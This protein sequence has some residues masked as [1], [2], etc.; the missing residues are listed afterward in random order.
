MA[1]LNDKYPLSFQIP[2]FLLDPN[3]M[4]YSYQNSDDAQSK[5]YPVQHLQPTHRP[6]EFDSP[7]SQEDAAPSTSHTPPALPPPFQQDLLYPPSAPIIP[8]SLPLYSASGFDMISILAK[9]VNRPNPRIMLGPV[10]MTCSFLVADIRNGGDA[11]IVYASPTFCRLTGYSEPEILGRNC[12]FLQ[13][14]SGSLQRGDPR[15][16]TAPDAVRHIHRS[17]IQDKECQASL[18]NYRKDGSAFVNLVTLIPVC[19]D[20][21]DDTLITHYV[22]FQVDLAEQPGAI[23]QRLRDGSY[24][25]NYSMIG[26][27][28]VGVGAGLGGMGSRRGRGVSAELIEML[29]SAQIGGSSIASTSGVAAATTGTPRENDRADVQAFVLE[30]S[31]DFIHVLSLKGSLLYVSPAITRVLGYT[32]SELVGRSISD[33]CHPADIVPVMRE[34]KEASSASAGAGS[35]PAQHPPQQRGQSMGKATTNAPFSFGMHG[36]NHGAH[37]PSSMGGMGMGMNMGMGMGMNMGIG[38]LGMNMGMGVTPYQQYQTIYPAEPS[39]SSSSN[40]YTQSFPPPSSHPSIPHHTGHS[41][42][43]QNQFYG[44]PSIATPFPSSSSSSNLSSSTPSNLSTF[45]TP[46]RPTTSLLFRAL[47]KNGKYVWLMCRGRLHVEPGKGRKAVVMV[48]RRVRDVVVDDEGGGRGI[49][50]GGLDNER[51][52]GDADEGESE[53][54]IVAPNGL[55]L[56]GSSILLHPPP[57]SPPSTASSSSTAPRK[58]IPPPPSPLST[59]SGLSP[60]G[61]TLT[62]LVRSSDARKVAEAIASAACAN[63]RR[64]VKRVRCGLVGLG[65]SSE[66]GTSSGMSEDGEGEGR[67]V[68]I[69]FYAMGRE[70]DNAE[71][72]DEGQRQGGQVLPAGIVF[73][74][75]WVKEST[76]T[77][78]GGFS[79]AQQQHPGY[80]TSASS[81]PTESSF[82]LNIH[83]V[84]IQPHPHSRSVSSRASPSGSSPAS[85]H[86]S[87]RIAAQSQSQSQSPHPLSLSPSSETSW[88]YELTKLRFENER[89]RAEAMRLER[90]ERRRGVSAGSSSNSVAGGGEGM[91]VQTGMKR[92]RE[93]MNG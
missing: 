25:V 76:S 64:G 62:S 42:R 53:W 63:G 14:P 2:S 65:S 21:D 17:L 5:Y 13:S 90:R 58:Q 52:E 12:R 10:D 54:G 8:S 93:E 45:A 68:E 36:M 37:N 71:S 40:P 41:H 88:Q 79:V 38:G 27:G 66:A 18:I 28:G 6:F 82:P 46:S 85:T 22:G 59:S 44:P 57:P 60:I 32:A 61:K 20:D 84:P 50:G 29:R 87:T 73:E 69:R 72:E 34:L 86:T 31:D 4:T 55:I 9:V 19:L 1:S 91:G 30:N 78:S 75:V 26:L 23:L 83:G 11:P 24:I 49:M 48:G 47:H 56:S 16:H 43:T 70:G 77:I 67:E 92:A 15:M 35:V 39:S 74:I 3:H 80:V 7:T 81:T 51:E 89:L 33:L